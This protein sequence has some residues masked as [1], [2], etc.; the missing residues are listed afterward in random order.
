MS[1]EKAGKYACY[2]FERKFLLRSLPDVLL[3]SQDYKQIEDR[4]FV[5]TNLRLRTV[6][7]AD[8][9]ILVR[10][11]TQKFIS[12]GSGLTKTTIT[13]I[14]LSESEAALLKQLQGYTI[15]K[16][17]YTFKSW[18]PNFFDRCI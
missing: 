12:E 5:G 11:F 18:K 15:K 8:G 14:Y 3:A 4:Y 10:K 13:N 17:R 16:N 6:R 2:E 9:K 1:H 7:S